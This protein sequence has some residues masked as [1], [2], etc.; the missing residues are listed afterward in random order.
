M[1]EIYDNLART[2][3][4]AL[5]SASGETA[6]DVAEAWMPHDTGS[7]EIRTRRI[8]ANGNNASSPES[9][10][11]WLDESTN[12][13]DADQS[14]LLRLVWM[15]A[16]RQDRCVKLSQEIQET[17]VDS[18]GLGQAYKYFRS[19]LTGITSLPVI[20]DRGVH[21]H[22]FAFGYAPKLVVLWSQ[23]HFP[24]SVRQRPLT[25]G[26]IL[27]EQ[28]KKKSLLKF[29][30]AT[31]WSAELYHCSMFP[32]L[33]LAL[34]LG[35]Q[36]NGIHAEVVHGVENLERSTGFHDYATLPLALRNPESAGRLAVVA[37]GYKGRLAST[38]RKIAVVDKLLRFILQVLDKE[39]NSQQSNAIN[40]AGLTCS[41]G[42]QILRSHVAVLQDRA[43]MQTLDAECAHKRVQIQIDAVRLSFQTPFFPS[44]T[45]LIASAAL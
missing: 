22:P 6:F 28:G 5:T 45:L 31:S 10:Q 44:S 23:T 3:I 38:D 18:F 35:I 37:S 26:I 13:E 33:M 24:A 30:Q 4:W 15:T 27:V 20:H 34:W 29:L 16:S 36:V 14:L 1:N 32:C 9:L 42:R 2:D 39:D 41:H 19:S 40:A 25:Q 11:R 12:R 7:I 21:T 43:D 8:D 17:L